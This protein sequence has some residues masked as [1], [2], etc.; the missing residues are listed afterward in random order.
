MCVLIHFGTVNKRRTHRGST[1]NHE[2]FSILFF[3]CISHTFYYIAVCKAMRIESN[4]IWRVT[5]ECEIEKSEE[6]TS[7]IKKRK[8]DRAE[9]TKCN[10]EMTEHKN[11]NKN[12]ENRFKVL[13]HKRKRTE[14]V[15]L[16]EKN[17]RVE[18][19]RTS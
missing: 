8:K 10:R 7:L 13:K 14:N 2:N 5:N 6:K 4:D 18:L 1:S 3:S 16:W 17:F 15:S 9:K 12:E 19:K 11:K